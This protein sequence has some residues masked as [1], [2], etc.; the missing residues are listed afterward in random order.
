MVSGKTLLPCVD[1]GQLFL[2]SSLHFILV[3]Y[4]GI[5]EVII[6]GPGHGAD[7]DLVPL[8]L[9]AAVEHGIEVRAPA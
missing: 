4:L 1:F 2:L 5:D 7:V 6:I 8:R 3:D 9:R